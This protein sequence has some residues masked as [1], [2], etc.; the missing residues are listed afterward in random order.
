[1]SKK[2][3]YMDLASHLIRQI[4]TEKNKK[5]MEAL[6][7]TWYG[8]AESSTFSSKGSQEKN[9]SSTLVER[10]SPYNDTLHPTRTHLL[11]K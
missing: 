3:E 11:H 2:R 4:Y 5:K 10:Q 6:R 7:Q 9:M 1:M 8:K